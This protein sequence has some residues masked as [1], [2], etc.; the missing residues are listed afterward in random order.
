MGD[1]SGSKQQRPTSHRNWERDGENGY[2]VHT[3][4]KTTGYDGQQR[5]V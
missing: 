5:I 3:E 1:P 4:V 2:S